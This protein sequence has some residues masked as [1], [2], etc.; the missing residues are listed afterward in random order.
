VPFGYAGVAI[1]IRPLGDDGACSSMVVAGNRIDGHTEAVAIAVFPQDPPGAE[2]S[3]ITI[4]ENEIVMRRVRLPDGSD[5]AGRLA[6]APAIRLYNAQRLVGQGLITWGEHWMPEGGWPAALSDGRISDVSVVGNHITGAVGVAIEAA[7][8]TASRIVDNEI[9]VRPATT[10]EEQDGLSVGGNGGPGVWVL[11]GLVDEVN[12]TPVWMSSGSEGT[13]V[14]TP[15][16]R[17]PG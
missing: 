1:G 4:Q 2:C 15:T 5:Q 6:I 13:V 14:R 16:G 9:E 3:H 11:L 7:H 12:G 10:P 8:V 17:P